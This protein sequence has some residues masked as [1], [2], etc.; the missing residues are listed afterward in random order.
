MVAD[1]YLSPVRSARLRAASRRTTRLNLHRRRRRSLRNHSDWIQQAR[2]GLGVRAR[3]D[4][5]AI[6]GMTPRAG[7]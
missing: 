2:A 3:L 5:L 4:A 1:A 6:A 7:G